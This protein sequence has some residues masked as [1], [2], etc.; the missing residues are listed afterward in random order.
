[1]SK[2]DNDVPLRGSERLPLPGARVSGKLNPNERLRVTVMLHP[3]AS[4]QE[5]LDRVNELGTRMPNERS[6]LTRDAFD[7]AYGAADEDLAKV[8]AFARENALDVVEESRS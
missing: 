6:Y 1:M 8:E 4:G 2:R 5:K 7:A 3:R